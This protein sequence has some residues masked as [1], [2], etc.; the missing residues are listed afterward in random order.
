MRGRYGG[1]EFNRMLLVLAIVISILSVLPHLRFLY[2]VGLVLL[3]YSI[4]RS[5]SRKIDKRYKE[6]VWYLKV[7]EKPRKWFGLQKRR[8]QERKVY[9]YYKCP[10][11]KRYNRV[12][13]GHG[14][15]E[16]RCPKC[17]K[18]YIRGRKK[19]A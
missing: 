8:F 19:K 6:R 10:G 17:S 2:L 16:I 12:P 4:Y 13:K 7:T 3:G 18:T 1:D 9:V 15:I 11:C 5:L 14:R